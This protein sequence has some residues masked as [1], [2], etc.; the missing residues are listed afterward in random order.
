MY[1]LFGKIWALIPRKLRLRVIRATQGKFTVSVAAVI[2]DSDGRVLLLRHAIRPAAGWGLPGGFM[3]PGE[4]PEDALRREI[5]EETSLELDLPTV[6]RIRTIDRHIEMLFRATP[7]GTARVNSG[8]ITEVGWFLP[9]ELPPRMSAV[10]KR[11]VAEVLASA[12]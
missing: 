10:Q 9:N 1:R 4:Q 8:E 5:R 7:V 3:A 2:S 6:I 12:V 11:L